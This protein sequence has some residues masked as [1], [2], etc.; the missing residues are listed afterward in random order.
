MINS[1]TPGSSSSSSSSSSSTSTVPFVVADFGCG[2]AVLAQR[3]ASPALPGC[4]VHSFDLVAPST[5]PSSASSSSHKRVKVTAC[6]MAHVPLPDKSCDAA[7]F[8]LSLM[9][10]NLADYLRE[11]RRILR[12][13]HG[14]LKIAEVR[15]RLEATTSEEGNESAQADGGGAS[16]APAAAA[17]LQVFVGQVEQ[18]GFKCVETNKKNRMFVIMEFKLADGSHDQATGTRGGGCR[19]GR[20]D[21]RQQKPPSQ[22]SSSPMSTIS[23]K[24]CAYKRR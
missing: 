12:R 20:K 8:C 13:P 11:A 17:G 9:G 7:V 4:T 16:S 18:L 24:P 5:P 22:P 10:T 2:D 19:K 1:A 3:C 23:A 6:D 21:T 14:V 15:S